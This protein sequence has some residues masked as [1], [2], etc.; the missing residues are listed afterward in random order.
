ME[1]TTHPISVLFLTFNAM[2]VGFFFDRSSR[3][4]RMWLLFNIVGVVMNLYFA[5]GGRAMTY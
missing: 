3:S 4:D 2:G 5:M 1:P